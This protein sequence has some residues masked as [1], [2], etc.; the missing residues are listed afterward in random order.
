MQRLLNAATW[1]V[2]GVRDEVRPYVGVCL[3]IG[4]VGSA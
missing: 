4:T 3:V 2:D 1:D